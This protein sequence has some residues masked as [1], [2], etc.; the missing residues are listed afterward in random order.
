MRAVH[1]P[2]PRP[3]LAKD[4]TPSLPKVSSPPVPVGP[5]S[6]APP[7][8]SATQI[9]SALSRYAALLRVRVQSDLRVPEEVRLM[10][11]QGKAKITFRLEPDGTVVWV[12]LARSSGLRV[13][14][15]AALRAVREADFPPFLKDMPHRATTFVIEVRISGNG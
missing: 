7:Q 14:D 11:L 3:I 2:Q 12:S 6:P 9:A 13:I 4:P 1:R 15:R 5:P 8:P 10:G